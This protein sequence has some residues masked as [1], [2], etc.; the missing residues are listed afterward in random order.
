MYV[1]DQTAGTPA[2]YHSLTP[3][4]SPQLLRCNGSGVQPGPQEV[5]KAPQVIPARAQPSQNSPRGERGSCGRIG[6]G[7]FLPHKMLTL[8]PCSFLVLHVLSPVYRGLCRSWRHRHCLGEY[9]PQDGPSAVPHFPALTL[10]TD[11][12]SSQQAW[13][14]TSVQFPLCRLTPCLDCR[15]YEVVV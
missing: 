14:S 11:F 15:K 1:W 10:I 8:A 5:W 6:G 7:H 2:Q 3:G 12:P 4:P 9:W 13:D